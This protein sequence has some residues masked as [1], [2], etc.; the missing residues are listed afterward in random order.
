VK[1]GEILFVSSMSVW[2]RRAC[3]LQRGLPAVSFGFA[4][5][6]L[7]L[8]SSSCSRQLLD[9]SDFSSFHDALLNR[10]LWQFLAR[11]P[12]LPVFHLPWPRVVHARADDIKGSPIHFHLS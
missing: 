8:Q 3:A 10:H 6:A 5:V 9:D 12:S 2:L 11:L 1:F 4:S 7:L